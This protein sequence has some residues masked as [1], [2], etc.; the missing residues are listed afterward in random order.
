[1]CVQVV[2]VCLRAR[3]HAAN[4]MPCFC[5]WNTQE[6]RRA[7]RREEAARSRL[8][9]ELRSAQ[10]EAR[11]LQIEADRDKAL[12]AD[13]KSIVSTLQHLTYLQSVSFVHCMLASLYHKATLLT[14]AECLPLRAYALSLC[15]R[16]EATTLQQ[17]QQ[18]AR[19]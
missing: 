19:R 3:S 12:I 1:M 14:T 13:L 5:F 8:A 11:R 18:A 2:L 7:A 10:E 16:C 9:A 4:A 15:C 6:H 17:Q